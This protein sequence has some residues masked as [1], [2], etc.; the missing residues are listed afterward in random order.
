L[1]YYEDLGRANYR[2]ASGHRLAQK[3]DLGPIFEQLSARFESTRLALND[4]SERILSINDPELPNSLLKS[5][6]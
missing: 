5:L 6:S 2:A 3:Y 4:L 1:R